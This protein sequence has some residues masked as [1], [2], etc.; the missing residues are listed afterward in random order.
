[1]A[2]MP[3]PQELL[4]REGPI[5]PEAA[6]T[7]AY[8][9]FCTPRL[10]RHRS[11][12]HD[13][14]VG[15]A[16]FYLRD[17]ERVRVASSEGEIQAYVLEPDQ[18][19]SQ[20]SVLMVHGWTGEAS[21]MSAFAEQIRRRGFRTVL[22]DFPAHGESAG[23][24][25]SLIGCAHAVREVSDA[26]GPID[27]VVAHSLGG[28]A[29][30][31]AGGGGPPMPRPY[32][33]RA[34]VLIAMPNRFADLTRDFGAEHRLSPAAQRVYEQH[35]EHLARRRIEDFTAVNL[36]AEAG[37]PA[38]LLHSRDDAEVPFD[39]AQQVARSSRSAYLQAFDGL[40]HRKILYAP[41]VVRAAASYLARQREL[42]SSG[43]PAQAGNAVKAKDALVI[44][45]LVPGI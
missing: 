14:L 6:G 39:D 44:P 21:F 11:P 8:R 31:L 4:R 25:T 5:S 24:R 16:R 42:T 13:V 22:L 23:H 15:R 37:R 35:L 26:L 10:S 7:A 9:I 2:H 27:F 29:S 32:S 43:R 45:G 40:G 41:P 17:A 38:L 3:A 33:F 18:G 12:D 19:P 30:L 1:M 20:G 34:Y 36:L 28:L